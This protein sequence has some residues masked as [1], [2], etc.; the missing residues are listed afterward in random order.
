MNNSHPP[1]NSTPRVTDYR[2]KMAEIG[3]L[4]SEFYLTAVE[5]LKVRK[6]IKQMRREK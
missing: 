2:Q 3:R 6:F 1:V 4:R 5:R